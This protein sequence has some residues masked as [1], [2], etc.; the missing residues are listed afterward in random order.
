MSRSDTTGA[1]ATTGCSTN[2]IVTSTGR[3][4]RASTATRPVTALARPFSSPLELSHGA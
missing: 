2:P 3:L 1:G 4:T